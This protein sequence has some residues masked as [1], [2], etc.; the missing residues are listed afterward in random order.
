[1]SNEKSHLITTS[2]I[3]SVK[4]ALEAP[5]SI[6]KPD[7]GG[8][9]ILT[10]KEKALTDLRNTLG[11]EKT[12]FPE[13]ARRGVEF[14]TKVYKVANLPDLNDLPGSENFKKVCKSIRGYKFYEKKG[15]T[16]DVDGKTCYLFGK[17][18]AISYEEKKIKDLKTTEKYSNGKYLKSFQH[19]MYCLISGEGFDDF[20]YV[21]AEWDSFPKIKAIHFEQ[22]QVKNRELLYKEV[23][24]E[25]QYCFEAINDFGLWDVYREK[26]CL[27]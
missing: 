23:E 3:G 21:V 15:V 2:L 18:D 4:W 27:Y 1:M 20:E 16:I 24:T 11:R 17:Y 12:D 25:I 10:W 5:N 19:K 8:D 13:P 9:G 26:Y 6:I 14:E 7:K 22:F